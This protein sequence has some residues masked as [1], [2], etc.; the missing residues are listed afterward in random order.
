MTRKWFVPVCVCLA[1]GARVV[2]QDTGERSVDSRLLEILKQRG[3][4]T[5]AEFGELRKLESDLRKE[6][7]L[8]ASV[9]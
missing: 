1:L 6:S 7:D 8:E 3:V 4:I 2:A 9:N 5:E